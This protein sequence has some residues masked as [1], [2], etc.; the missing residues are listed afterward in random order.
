[1]ATITVSDNF[2]IPIAEEFRS[3]LNI[4]P[5]QKIKL[6]QKR[7][8]IELVPLEAIQDARGFLKGI[9]TTNITD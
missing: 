9:R 3:R 6:V 8:R 1:M 7:G 5:G 4:K 2:E